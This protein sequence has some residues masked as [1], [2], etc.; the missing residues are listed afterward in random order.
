MLMVPA[1]PST[2]INQERLDFAHSYAATD[3]FRPPPPAADESRIDFSRRA[4]AE[5]QQAL[6]IPTRGPGAVDVVVEASG[7]EV[8]IQMAFYL[9]ASRSS[10]LTLSRV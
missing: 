9:G 1:L 3:L 8:C 5:L 7:A 2:D 6:G 4:T 10:L